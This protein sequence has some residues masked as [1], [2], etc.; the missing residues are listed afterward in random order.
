[1]SFV[2][3]F[4]E[5][6]FSVEE[7][8]RYAKSDIHDEKMISLVKELIN[9]AKNVFSYKVCY[10]IFPLNI[11]G[12]SIDLGAF[13]F[14]S[15]ALAKSLQ[16]SS[17]IIVFAA[18]VGVGIDRLINKYSSISPSKALIFQ[19]IGTERIEALCDMF[20]NELEQPHTPRFSP[21]YGDLPLDCQKDIF[22]LLDCQKNIGLTLNDSMLMSPMKSVTAFIGLKEV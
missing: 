16:N 14:E 8:L 2:K 4:T 1:M 3:I 6:P 13:S 10:S 22:A 21:G 11:K 15:K 20:C 5:P 7:I 17:E 9:E 19:A 12:E 18:T